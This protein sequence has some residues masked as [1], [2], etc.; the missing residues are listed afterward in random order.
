MTKLSLS[1]ICSALVFSLPAYCDLVCKNADQA[2]SM[3][4][5][6]FETKFAF[7]K[8]AAAGSMADKMNT[9]GERKKSLIE[10]TMTRKVGPRVDKARD[11][12]TP[13]PENPLLLACV[14]EER[15][16]TSVKLSLV[17]TSLSQVFSIDRM[18]LQSVVESIESTDLS[19][20]EIEKRVVFSI[21]F[22]G[23]DLPATAA[24]SLEFN[25]D[26]CT[27]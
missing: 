17:G 6:E 5:S 13:Q 7:E 11:A 27:F 18:T 8:W 24:I 9:T 4:H 10:A 15:Q 25:A 14:F 2:F 16:P 23:V 3:S 1:L 19:G 26:D 20:P 22:S 12:C 21:T